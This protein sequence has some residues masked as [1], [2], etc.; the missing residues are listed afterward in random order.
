MAGQSHME[1]QEISRRPHMEVTQTSRGS[2]IS[3]L[4]WSDSVPEQR[5]KQHLRNAVLTIKSRLETGKHRHRDARCHPTI[6]RLSELSLRASGELGVF[7]GPKPAYTM[8]IA[9]PN[10][11]MRYRSWIAWAYAC[12][13]LSREENALTSIIRVERGT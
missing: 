4:S 9:S 6:G 2:Q 12:M 8:S 5:R 13:R 1:F 7:H 3:E 10:D 11:S